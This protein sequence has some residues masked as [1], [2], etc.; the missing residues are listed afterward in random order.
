MIYNALREVRYGEGD[1]RS[2]MIATIIAN[3]LNGILGYLFI[4]TF[5]WG[6]AGAAWA[7]VAAQT[8]EALVLAA[9][10][11]RD[12]WGISA[13]RRSHLVS[14]I[15]IG[16]P[17]GLQML[18]EVGAFAVLA[19]MIASLS[20]AQMAAH[21]IAL[22]VISFSFLPAF[23][24]GESAS[25]L[26]GQVVG[27]ARDDL[28]LPLTKLAL[29]VVTAYTGL[30]TLVFAV[31][32]TYIVDVFHAD[33]DT[34]TIAIRLVR[35]ATLFLVMDGANIVARTT[36]RGTGDVRFPAVVGVVC[37]WLLTPPLAWL[38]GFHFGMG[39]FGGW[40][41]MSGEVFLGAL[42]QWFRLLRG[43]WR[44]HAVRTRGEVLAAADF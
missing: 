18:L 13:M 1:A 39:A 26:V 12:G 6:V 28:V 36:L 8:I 7:T 20:A 31:F 10:Q 15:R 2:P 4:F 24:V 5:G 25:V 30:C 16:V 23:A 11:H 32:A 19:A 21:Q 34:R 40:L 42:I 43:G 22:Q 17:T 14:L 37:S 27:A 38:L 29:R 9:F 35:I 41:G 44:E 33:A 3:V